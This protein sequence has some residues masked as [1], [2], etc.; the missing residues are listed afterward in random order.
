V[1]GKFGTEGNGFREAMTKRYGEC[2]FV[3]SCHRDLP[4]TVGQHQLQQ[5][6]Q[7]N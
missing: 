5:A 1:L 4:V 3:A 6:D 7:E 2:R